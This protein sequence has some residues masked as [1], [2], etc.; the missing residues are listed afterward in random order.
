MEIIMKKI[1]Y[2]LICISLNF[3]YGDKLKEKNDIKITPSDLAYSIATQIKN[4]AISTD[5]D[6]KDIYAEESTIVM[7]MPENFSKDIKKHEKNKNKLDAK[8]ELLSKFTSCDLPFYSSLLQRNLKIKMIYHE[9]SK[10][11]GE[12][13]IDKSDCENIQIPNSITSDKMI[14][15]M[16]EVHKTKML[17]EKQEKK[18]IQEIKK[19]TLKKKPEEVAKLIIEG[20]LNKPTNDNDMM[21]TEAKTNGSIA[22]ITYSFKNIK[23]LYGIELT[24]SGKEKIAKHI[25]ALL[26][27]TLCNNPFGNSIFDTGFQLHNIYY[28][29]NEKYVD[30]YIDK[31]D[32]N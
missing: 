20:V 15:N 3:A 1:L 23:S 32:C 13:I 28:Y 12:Y 10:T 5:N 27:L 19:V 2:I 4:S 26:S 11:I 9:N 17:H 8:L 18:L 25:K 30:F 16:I 31:T 24:Y 6:Y 14:K 21:L 29:N 7:M 22:E